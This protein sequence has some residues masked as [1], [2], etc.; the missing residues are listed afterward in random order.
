MDSSAQHVEVVPKK[1]LVGV[2]EQKFGSNWRIRVAADLCEPSLREYSIMLS[3]HGKWADLMPKWTYEEYYRKL[4]RILGMESPQGFSNYGNAAFTAAMRSVLRT[5][6]IVKMDDSQRII[7][8]Q[9]IREA[10]GLAEESTVVL[11]GMVTRVELWKKEDFEKQLF[12][13]GNQDL[14]LVFNSV[15]LG[16]G[17]NGGDVG[18]VAL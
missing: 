9:H 12:N 15:G 16:A 13:L 7:V 10:L 4:R 11:I 18:S 5:H 8:P 1:N 3:P 6:Q 14:S 17:G 2:D